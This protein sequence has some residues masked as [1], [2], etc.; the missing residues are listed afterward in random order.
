MKSEPRTDIHILNQTLSTMNL[1][2]SKL[3]FNFPFFNASLLTDGIVLAIRTAC[4]IEGQNIPLSV[5][6]GKHGH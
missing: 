2:N 1:L 4:Y 3:L 6:F 5:L